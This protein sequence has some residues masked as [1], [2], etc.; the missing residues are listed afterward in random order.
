M[1][2][3]GIPS[4]TSHETPPRIPRTRPS[5]VRPLPPDPSPTQ[6]MNPTT[7]HHPASFLRRPLSRAT[8]LLLA[9]ALLATGCGES[10]TAPEV[11]RGFLDGTPSNPQIGV[12]VSS[13][14]AAVEFFQLGDPSE[15]RT[16]ELG[17]GSSITPTGLALHGR[18]MVV[19]LGNAASVAVV[20][21]EDMV[22]TRFFQF[23]GGNATGA[24]F[25]DANTVIAANLLDDQV[26]RFTLDQSGTAITQLVSVA[27][28]PTSVHV[29]G[30]RVVVVSSNL[31]ENWA[32]L[33]EGVATIL[34]PTTLEVLATVETGGMNP[35]DAALGPDG[36][37]WVVHAGDWVSEGSVSVI[38]PVAGTLVEV[39]EG[40]GVGPGSIDVDSH[41]RVHVSG[42]FFGTVIW[43][44]QARTFLRSPANPVCAPLAAGGCRGAS[45]THTDEEG[46]LHQLFFGSPAEGLDPMIF[47]YEG[48]S[49]TLAD[50]IPT[51]PGP[52]GLVITRF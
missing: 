41:G 17:A 18:R 52:S 29:T 9:L 10:S 48:A 35:A 47:V 6:P 25:V 42:Y 30:G 26:G 16:V 19:P 43:D 14:G 12:V 27:P 5:A 45:G 32:P 44:A 15:T 2:S 8:G 7:M 40:F 33:G 24:A 51:V 38:D 37:V 34:D 13:L 3:P 22:T 4:G 31:D 36:R 49:Y 23:A 21:P 1:S 11:E 46:R 39:H 50:S 20:D 28:R